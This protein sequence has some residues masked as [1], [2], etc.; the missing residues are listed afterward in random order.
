MDD[1]DDRL[2]L[3]DFALVS[4][5]ARAFRQGAVEKCLAGNDTGCFTTEQ[6]QKAYDAEGDRTF[7]KTAPVV[8]RWSPGL[9]ETH[10]RSMPDMVREV[11][12]GVWGAVAI[13]GRGA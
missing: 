9:A 10:L 5:M 8:S 13:V 3:A 7:S 11:S 6:Y 12:P 2:D 4:M 1:D